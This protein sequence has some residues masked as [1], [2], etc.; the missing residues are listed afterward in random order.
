MMMR[1]MQ[2]A[3]PMRRKGFT[4]KGSGKM[5]FRNPEK[6]KKAVHDWLH[7][8]SIERAAM[9]HN[10][11]TATVIRYIRHDDDLSKV[12]LSRK[13][14]RVKRK[15]FTEFDYEN[16]LLLFKGG[17]SVKEVAMEYDISYSTAR[18]LQF[19]LGLR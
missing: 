12:W 16:I 14:H 6:C 11:S 19:E 18:R 8:E 9:N 7:G 5:R 2:S 15:L 1:L 13:G 10:M 17:M 3:L 4:G